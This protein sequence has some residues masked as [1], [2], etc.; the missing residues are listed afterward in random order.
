VIV[1]AGAAGRPFLIRLAQATERRRISR[2]A[3]D[4]RRRYGKAGFAFTV[5][6]V[7]NEDQVG[8]WVVWT[9]PQTVSNG[10]TAAPGAE[11]GPRAG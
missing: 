11:G 7:P 2:S 1:K 3:S 8:M 5:G 6:S 4:Y 10:G 9:P